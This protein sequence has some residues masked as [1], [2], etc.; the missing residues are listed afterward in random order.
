MVLMDC[1]LCENNFHVMCSSTL[2]LRRNSIKNLL[3]DESKSLIKDSLKICF[4]CWYKY[5]EEPKTLLFSIEM[6]LIKI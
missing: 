1:G 6:G 2:A 3:P 5:T 4:H